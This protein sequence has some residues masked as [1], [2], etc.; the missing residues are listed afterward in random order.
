MFVVELEKGVWVAPWIGDPGRTLKIENAKRFKRRNHARYGLKM[1]RKYRPFLK[2]K[3]KHITMKTRKEILKDL[4][5][6]LC[7][8]NIIM[9]VYFLTEKDHLRGDLSIDTLGTIEFIVKIE[10]L[11]NIDI[12]DKQAFECETIK[13]YIDLIIEQLN[14]A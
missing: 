13:D 8:I 3:I 4:S 9:S 6:I 5:S 10:S 14:K 2:A 11:Y 1:A 12:P 7:D